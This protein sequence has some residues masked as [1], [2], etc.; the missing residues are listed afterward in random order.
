MQLFRAFANYDP[1]HTT[2]VRALYE[3][4][5][6][7]RFT[8][9]KRIIK[10]VVLDDDALGLRVNARP[11]RKAF[12]FPRSGDKVSAFMQW[13][14]REV[15]NGVLE[16]LPGTTLRRAAQESWQNTYIQTAYQKGLASA[17]QG[18]KGAGVAVSG[19]W[20]E[21]AFFQPIH[22]DR[23][24]LIYTRS[25]S[26]LKGITDAM[27]AKISQVLARGLAEGI[28]LRDLAGDLLAEVDKIG[29]TRARALA[30]TEVIAAH[31][32]ASLNTYEEAGI[33]GV[34]ARAEFATARDNK[35]CPRCAA[36]EGRP[37]TLVEA[38]GVIPVHPNCRCAWIPIVDDPTRVRGLR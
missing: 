28:G 37:F 14:Q 26:G 5:I 27:D 9:I 23:V 2:R 24:G 15:E 7:R 10:E 29:I 20:I 4:D 35:V 34:N 6:A 33:E 16:V 19:R 25:Y 1:T 21:T 11:G 17:A 3:R 18:L 32:E 30:R 12:N 8:R 31:A 22:A 13:L 36:L 38:R